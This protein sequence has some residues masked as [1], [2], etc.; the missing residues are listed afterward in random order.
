MGSMSGTLPPI[1]DDASAEHHHSHRRYIAFAVIL[2]T[3]ILT[4]AALSIA[5]V[6]RTS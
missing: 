6:V 1:G 5:V 3:V 4:F 2:G